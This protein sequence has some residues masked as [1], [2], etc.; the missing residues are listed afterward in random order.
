MNRTLALLPLLALVSGCT[1]I[2]PEAVEHATLYFPPQFK[3]I[4]EPRYCFS[5]A[6]REKALQTYRKKGA[7]TLFELVIDSQGKVKKARLLRT[8]VDT[9]YHEDM[10]NHA[11]SFEFTKDTE[12]HRFRAFF[13]P[14]KYKHESTFEWI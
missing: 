10:E 9:I 2:P 7:D 14:T 13:F 4:D 5:P 11:R 8:H 6:E 3:Y 12:G 1:S